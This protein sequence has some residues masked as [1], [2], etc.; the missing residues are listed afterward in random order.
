M[1]DLAGDTIPLPNNAYPQT[2]LSGP[3]SGAQ[4][5]CAAFA[6]CSAVSA[7]AVLRS[8]RDNNVDNGTNERTE[9]EEAA[10]F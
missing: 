8:F 7:V 4:S 3:T 9:E 5:S 1:N 2:L 10:A 6:H